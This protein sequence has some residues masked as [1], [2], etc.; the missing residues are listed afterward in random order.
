MKIRSLSIEGFRGALHPLTLEFGDAFTI[1]SGRNGS[2]KSTICDAFEYLLT[3]TLER[4]QLDTEKGER[5]SD[6]LWWRG[7]SSPNSRYVK[8]ILEG[9]D[10]EEYAISRGPGG[11]QD[12]TQDYEAVV[13]EMYDQRI[14]PES[15]I[16]RLC[17][18][19]I[20]RD[21]TITRFSTDLGET[22]RFDFV[23]RV[24]GLSG[25]SRIEDRVGQ[26]I[27]RLK[28]AVAQRRVEYDRARDEVGRVT[29]DLSQARVASSAAEGAD[30][31]RTI[32]SLAQLLGE[33]PAEITAL[34]KVARESVSKLRS[35]VDRFEGVSAGLRDLAPERRVNMNRQVEVLALRVKEAEGELS[36]AEQNLFKVA[37]VLDVAKKESPTKEAL[38]Q[39]AA[40]GKQL[41]LQNGRCPLCGSSLPHRNSTNTCRRF[42]MNSTASA[43]F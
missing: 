28:T 6:Y 7:S 26:V 35:E 1:I 20:I 22:E 38:A 14:A 4:F 27:Q 40:Y 11:T 13:K 34:V 3:G 25:F 8:L 32:E 19:S 24:I 39:L 30:L 16:P 21:E 29:S 12:G 9:D 42:G 18:T 2:G 17:Q 36:D 33:K 37:A 23:N 15:P 10:G 43:E 31:K 5:I 41:G